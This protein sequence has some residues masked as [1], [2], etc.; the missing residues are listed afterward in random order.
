MKKILLPLFIVLIISTIAYAEDEIGI[1]STREEIFD[2]LGSPTG[3]MRS[4]GTVTLMYEDAMV[5]LRD[6][7]VIYVDYA[8]EEKIAK[9][10][11]KR[12]FE[13]EQKKQGLIK[14]NG[15]WLTKKEKAKKKSRALPAVPAIKVYAQGGKSID[16]KKVIVPGKITIIDFYADW[17]GPCRM[18][19]P[20]LEK[21]AN[22]DVDV[23]LRKID[24]VNWS[25][26]VV[27]QYAIRS[28]PNVRVFDRKGN[29]I[30]SPTSD[31]NKI[32]KYIKKAK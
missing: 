8:L 7:K 20:Y 32:K 9:G 3:E 4:G 22:S 5:E 18:I 23:Y 10:K 16:L 12:A 21:I 14:H 2:I 1:G 11:E 27:K 30:G 31:I 29:M 13:A 24:I 26:S 28:V 17:C 25:S 6:E 15:E 19:S